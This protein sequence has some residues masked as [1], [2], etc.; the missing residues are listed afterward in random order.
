LDFLLALAL[1]HSGFSS[2]FSLAVSIIVAGAA[3]YFAL[4]RWG[5]PDR[6]SGFSG[7]R[8]LG[9]GIAE[10][11]TYCIRMAALWFWK[12]HLNDMEPTEHLVGLAVAYGVGFLFGYFFR[13]GIVFPRQ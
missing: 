2:A 10:A 7:K 9:S 11:G 5:F 3:E 6:V 12:S 8:L 1:L 4:E 13:R